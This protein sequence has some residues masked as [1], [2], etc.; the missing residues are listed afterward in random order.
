MIQEGAWRDDLSSPVV[1]RV[2]DPAIGRDDDDLVWVGRFTDAFQNPSVRTPRVEDTDLGG[3]WALLREG[4]GGRLDRRQGSLSFVIAI[5][6]DPDFV[7]VRFEAPGP[8]GQT[9][10]MV[11]GP[12]THAVFTMEHSRVK[13]V[14]SVDQPG[15]YLGRPGR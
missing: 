12:P 6:R 1:G 11:T 9:V 14:V 15:G 3:S 5:E 13:N 4:S 7:R 8:F 10:A 2:G